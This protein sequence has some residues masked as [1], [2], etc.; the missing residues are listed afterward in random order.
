MKDLTFLNDGNADTID[1]NPELINFQKLRQLE[2]ILEQIRQHQVTPYSFERVQEVQ[3]AILSA[4][5]WDEVK[6]YNESLICEDRQGRT[7]AMRGEIVECYNDTV[8]NLDLNLTPEQ[9]LLAEKSH[10]EWSVH[11]IIHHKSVSLT[12]LKEGHSTSTWTDHC[13]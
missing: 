3:N 13:F 1:S 11:P 2:G 7:P 6:A 12:Q 10:M 8:I 4:E 5:V 9:R